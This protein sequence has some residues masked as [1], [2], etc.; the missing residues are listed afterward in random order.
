Q[1][2][3]IQSSTNWDFHH[4]IERRGP[5]AEG[6]V[7]EAAIGASFVASINTEVDVGLE[8]EEEWITLAESASYLGPLLKILVIAHSILSMGMLVTCYFLKVPLVIFKREKEV[9]RML[10]FQGIWIVE[11][12]FDE[13]LRAQWDKSVLSTPSF[14]HMYW[15]KFVKKKV[16]QSIESSTTN[17][18]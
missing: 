12:S 14:P 17:S 1:A 8:E 13:R 3:L 7:E 4:S 18:R 15:D 11:Q 10:E 2:T 5:G 6:T 16:L 9:S